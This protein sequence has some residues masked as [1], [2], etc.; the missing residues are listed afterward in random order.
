MNALVVVSGLPGT[1]KSA[2]AAHAARTLRAVMLSKDIFEAALWRS[3]IT[4]DSGAGWA[5]Y[6]QLG[7]VAESQLRLGMAVVLDSVAPNERIRSAWRDLAARTEARFIAIECVCSDE[8]LHRSRLEGRNRNIPGWPEVSW[9]QVVEV[10]SRYE[11]WSGDRLVV[12]AVRPIEENLAVVDAYL[13]SYGVAVSATSASTCALERNPR[14]RGER[15]ATVAT[16]RPMS[17]ALIAAPNAGPAAATIAP[18]SSCALLVSPRL[19][20]VIIDITRPRYASAV[21][22]CAI[23]F[24]IAPHPASA[25]PSTKSMANESAKPTSR[26]RSRA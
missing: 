5:G 19:V 14:R 13:R 15:S 1:G 4:R 10:R 22:S 9:V 23:V 16:L 21:A 24:R 12:D 8:R 17:T 25:T 18:V 26:P 3:G 7:A 11:P 20:T 2:I 6:E